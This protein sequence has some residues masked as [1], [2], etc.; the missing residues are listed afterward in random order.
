VLVYEN[1]DGR[2]CVEYDKP[3]SLFGRLGNAYVTEV[4]A[5]LDRKLEQWVAKAIGDSRPPEG[6]TMRAIQIKA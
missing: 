5:M 2:T 1:D 6:A 4:A 3:S